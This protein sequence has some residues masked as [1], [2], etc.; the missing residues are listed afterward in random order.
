MGGGAGGFMGGGSQNISN[1]DMF[2]GANTNPHPNPFGGNFS[3]GV[4]AF[5]PNRLAKESASQMNYHD[6]PY[7]KYN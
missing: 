1:V 2:V 3:S 4:T 5:D 6:S 7:G